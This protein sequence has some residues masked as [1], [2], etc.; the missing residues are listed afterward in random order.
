MLIL[1]ALKNTNENATNTELIKKNPEII[2]S[3][4]DN[5]K[6]HQASQECESKNYKNPNFYTNV[7]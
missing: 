5:E 2:E 6:D 3:Q 7:N 4:R 1:F